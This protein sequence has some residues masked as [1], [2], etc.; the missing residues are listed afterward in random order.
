ML[1][2]MTIVGATLVLF[3][4]S[5]R[6]KPAPVSSADLSAKLAQQAAFIPQ[7]EPLSSQLIEVAQRYQLPMGIE[8]R[9]MSGDAPAPQLRAAATVRELLDAII[10]QAP[11]LQLTVGNGLI[12]VTSSVA[13][14]DSH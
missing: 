6:A 5:F 2:L 4:Q 9:A 7:P 8:V 14:A 3:G 10:S 13:A 1:A 12:H 11:D